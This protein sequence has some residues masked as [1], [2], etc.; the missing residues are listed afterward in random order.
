MLELI[1]D[2][3]RYEEFA[4]ARVLDA[5]ARAPFDQLCVS[6]L[7]GFDP[8]RSSLVHV[9]W[10]QLLWLYRWQGLPPV[11][12]Y[13]V[14][15]FPG[16]AALRDRLVEIDAETNAFIDTLTDERLAAGFSYGG[17][18]GGTFTYPLWKAMLH[19][20]NHATY[21]RGE[22]AAVLTHLGYSPGELDFFRMYDGRR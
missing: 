17:M 8:V 22:V 6:V 19:Q 15:D 14:E 5:A 9:M 7:P 18:D 16:L 3:Y 12:H 11:A 20:A 4:S 13:D 1:R 21:H 2:Y 10:A